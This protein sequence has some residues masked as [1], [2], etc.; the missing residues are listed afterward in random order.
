MESLL[1]ELGRLRY[2][3]RPISHSK[4]PLRDLSSWYV[5]RSCNDSLLACRSNLR[6]MIGIEGPVSTEIVPH[7]RLEGKFTSAQERCLTK[8]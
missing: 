1:S 8:I 6:V 2:V 3:F 5:F 4:P 7:F